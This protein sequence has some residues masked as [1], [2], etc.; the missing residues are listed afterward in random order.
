AMVSHVNGL[1]GSAGNFDSGTVLRV[2]GNGA[3]IVF[4]SAA[5]NL[6]AGPPQAGGTSVVF[7]WA[8]A[9]SSVVRIAGPNLEPV[10][11]FGDTTAAVVSR[12]GLWVALISAASNLVPGA[13]NGTAQVY[14]WDATA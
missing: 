5:T 4:Q 3:S 1:P 9:G 7:R 6:V 10:S 13:S 2:A 11:G 8:A 12:D 14:L